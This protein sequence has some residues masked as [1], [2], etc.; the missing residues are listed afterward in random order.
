MSHP[1]SSK[2][3]RARVP[4]ITQNVSFLFFFFFLSFVFL[5]PHLWHMDVPRLGIKLEL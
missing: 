5:R 1:V 3:K 2:G 4:V